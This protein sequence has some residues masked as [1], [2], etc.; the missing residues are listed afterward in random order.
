MAMWQCIVLI[1]EQALCWKQDNGI[2]A[3]FLS[4]WEA[5]PDNKTSCYHG[6]PFLISRFARVGITPKRYCVALCRHHCTSPQNFRPE[7]SALGSLVSLWTHTVCINPAAINTMVSLLAGRHDVAG[8]G[9]K[10]MYSPFLWP[11]VQKEIWRR[12]GATRLYWKC[13]QCHIQTTSEDLAVSAE[14][15]SSI[16][17]N[18]LYFL[19]SSSMVQLKS[20]T[21]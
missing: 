17:F 7:T 4:V 6:L 10:K 18:C 11:S 21:A 8:F 14:N 16:M 19:T 1:M 12:W 9:K 15:F 20:I 3:T 2:N 5:G 13:R